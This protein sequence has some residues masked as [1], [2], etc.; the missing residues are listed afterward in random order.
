MLPRGKGERS[1]DMPKLMKKVIPSLLLVAILA[2][3]S[4]GGCS[5]SYTPSTMPWTGIAPENLTQQ[6]WQD[7]VSVALEYQ[8][9]LNSYKLGVMTSIGTEVA[10]GINPWNRSLNI[11]LSGTKNLTDDQTQITKNMSMMMEGLGQNGEEQNVYYDTYALD[12]WIYISMITPTMGSYWLRSKKIAELEEVFSFNDVE[13]QITL[14][15]PASSI[16]Y[17][18]TEKVNTVD[19]YVLS[20]TPNSNELANWLEGQDTGLQNLDWQKVVDDASALKD[21]NINCYLAKDSYR[22]MRISINMNIELTPELADKNSSAF[23]TAKIGINVD[24]ML[25]DHNVPSTITLPTDAYTAK[26]VSSDVFLN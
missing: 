21:L 1:C 8:Q 5:S 7:I 19:C 25:Y 20:I 11:G 16:E 10:G 23:D 22:I 12:N 14:L 3:L 2:L 13:K 24:T 26:E 18:R 4:F 6:Q 15:K 9:H 17:L